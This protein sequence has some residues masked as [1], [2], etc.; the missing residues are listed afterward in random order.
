MSIHRGLPVL[1]ILAVCGGLLTL[2]ATNAQALR[3][4]GTRV[5]RRVKHR[6][7]PSKHHYSK[8]SARSHNAR[9]HH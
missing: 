1:V 3:V 6:A 4:R 5:T 8:R 7:K 9:H 2:P